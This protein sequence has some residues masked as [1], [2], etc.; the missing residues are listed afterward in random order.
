MADKFTTEAMMQRITTVY[1]QLLTPEI[2]KGE[3]IALLSLQRLDFSTSSS[4][5]PSAT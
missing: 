1:N 4:E 3:K 5:P 2:E